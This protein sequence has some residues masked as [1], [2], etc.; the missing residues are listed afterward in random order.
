MESRKKYHF[1]F[2]K[3]LLIFMLAGITLAFVLVFIL[4]FLCGGGIHKERLLRVDVGDSE[5][6]E[7]QAK[8]Q[9]STTTKRDSQKD[10]KDMELTFY[11]T[12]PRKEGIA[13]NQTDAFKNPSRIDKDKKQVNQRERANTV[14]S[15][16]DK[17]TKFL[18]GYTIQVGS[19]QRIEQAKKLAEKLDRKGYPAYIVSTNIPMQGMWHRVRVGHF[20]TMNEA[21][22]SRVALEMQERLPTYITFI[23][24]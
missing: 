13:H 23:S 4:G 14:F 2:S 10:P 21:K 16:T 11:Q 20:E 9:I 1:F 22:R 8:D 7:R 18:Y 5:I 17:D 19:F 24:K 6:E 12:L 3:K 15:Q